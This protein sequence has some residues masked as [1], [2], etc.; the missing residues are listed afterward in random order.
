M[1]ARADRLEFAPP[2]TPGMLRAL[3]LAIVAHLLL[4]AALTTGLSWKRDVVL[5]AEAE[6]WS[7]VPMEAAPKAIE[8]VPPPEPEPPAAPVVAVKPPPEVP[9]QPDADIAAERDKQL[10]KAKEKK[11][12]V[13]KI[14]EQARLKKEKL[15]KEKL[16]KELAKKAE[17]EKLAL[18]KKKNALDLKRKEALKAQEETRQQDARRQEHIKRMA[19]LAG[20]TG[21]PGATGS[22]L[23]ASGPSAGYGGRIRARIKPN[24]VFTED[25]AGNPTAEV[26]VRT[27]PDGTIIS[28]TLLKSSGSTSWDTAVLKAIDKTEV[29]PRDVD[30]RVPPSL[31]ISFRP[32][33]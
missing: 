17:K 27:S 11:L 23:H 14:L 4:L 2:A 7:A 26:D 29:L 31:V 9:V 8:E 24:I 20:A 25:I 13:Q 10:K 30:G 19:G 1:H 28:R 6:L 5:S 16:D 12:A 32:K 18:D 15:D 22:A 3:S 33:D 21:S